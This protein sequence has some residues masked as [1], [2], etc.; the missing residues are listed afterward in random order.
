MLV[1]LSGT[2]GTGKSSIAQR[3]RKKDYMI[4]DVNSIAFEHHFFLGKDIKRDSF[5]LDLDK[6]ETHISSYQHSH[7]LVLIEGHAAHL[8][9]SVDKILLLRCHPKELITRLQKKGWTK[10]KILENAQAEALDIILCEAIELHSPTNIFEITTSQKNIDEI[11]KEI[12]TILDSRF[13]ST[14]YKIGKIDWSEE[15]LQPYLLGEN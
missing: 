1:A 8:L 7:D 15:L 12:I 13:Q 9:P 6:L 4:L 14:K 11:V 5:I 2:P 3:L 10:D